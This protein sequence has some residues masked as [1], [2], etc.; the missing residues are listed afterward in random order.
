M[1]YILTVLFLWSCSPDSIATTSRPRVMYGKMNLPGQLPP[2]TPQYVP[3]GLSPKIFEVDGQTLVPMNFEDQRLKITFDISQKTSWATSQIR[4]RQMKDGRAYFQLSASPF[5]VKLDGLPV[6]ISEVQDPEQQHQNYWALNRVSL[7]EGEHVMSLEYELPSNRV[8]FYPDAGLGFLTD[9]TDLYQARFFEYWGPASFEQDAFRMVME[10]EIQNSNIEHQIFSNGQVVQKSP[11]SWTIDFPDYFTSSSFYVHLTDRKLFVKKGVI[12]GS[13][14]FF[15]VTVY[16]SSDLLAQSAFDSLPRIFAELERDYGPY[17]HDRFIAYINP[18]GGGMEYSGATITGL[19][20]LE[21]EMFHSWFARGVLPAEGRSG[22]ID[23]AMASWRDYGYFQGDTS[24]YRRP[25]NLSDY[26]SYRKSTA[27][28]SYLDGRELLADLDV[29]FAEFGGMKVLMR[30]FFERYQRRVVTTEEFWSFLKLKTAKNIDPYFRRY[31][32]Q[33]GSDISR[34]AV[35]DFEQTRSLHPPPL[36]E[37]E[38]L[39]LR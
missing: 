26:S 11:S 12:A 8:T 3:R 4:F 2:L 19:N 35:K 7:A 28:N 23:E 5:S 16:S 25:T 20:A 18:G 14:N 38:I 17:V 27:P 36:T 29:V 39:N 10:L 15:P 31:V 13:Q 33:Q 32:F 21:H 1:V 34:Q 24:L 30:S 6:E 22:W 37:Q 9:M